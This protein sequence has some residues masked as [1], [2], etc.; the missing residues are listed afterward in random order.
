MSRFRS[1]WLVF[2]QHFYCRFF[3]DRDRC[4]PEVWGR[5]LDGPWHCARCVPCYADLKEMVE[6]LQRAKPAARG[7]SPRDR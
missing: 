3:H 7:G 4:Y 2:K 1:W 6:E 5:G